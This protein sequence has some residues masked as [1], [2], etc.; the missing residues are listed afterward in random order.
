MAPIDRARRTLDP[1]A[2][3]WGPAG[4][5]KTTTLRSVHGAFDPATRG[6]LSSVDTE[7]ERTYFFDYAPLDLPRWRGF[8]L[9]AHAYTVPGQE[10]YV[11]TRRRILRGADAV[12]F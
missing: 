8:S 7:D 1:R 10:A 3:S 11:E 9:R 4:G 2:V 5:G 12:L 6:E